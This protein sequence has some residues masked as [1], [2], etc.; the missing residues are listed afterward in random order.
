[1]DTLTLSSHNHTQLND[2]VPA[3]LLIT[4]SIEH[5]NVSLSGNFFGNVRLWRQV[6]AKIAVPSSNL[7]GIVPK[8][9]SGK[10]GDPVAKVKNRFRVSWDP[11]CK[12]L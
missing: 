8:P 7:T 11:P 6:D 4:P 3:T 12:N 5:L 1:M 10:T 2:F 9:N